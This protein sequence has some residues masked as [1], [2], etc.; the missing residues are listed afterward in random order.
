MVI[1]A[2]FLL[3]YDIWIAMLIQTW[4]FVAFNKVQTA[5]YILWYLTLMP[6]V[7]INNNLARNK[8]WMGAVLLLMFGAGIHWMFWAY[9]FEFVGWHAFAEIQYACYIWFAINIYSL[10]SFIVNHRM[11]ITKLIVE[12]DL[13]TGT[14]DELKIKY[15]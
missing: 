6:I 11:T 4:A 9:H 14:D 12:E 8:V 1:L 10:Y 3:Y 7:F 15:E 13:K 2:G 5:Q